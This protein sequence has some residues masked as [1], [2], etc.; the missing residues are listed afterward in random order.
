MVVTLSESYNIS[1][2][3]SV[4]SDSI[5]DLDEI[6]QQD[7]AVYSL[8]SQSGRTVNEMKD[9]FNPDGE[10]FERQMETA[11]HMEQT[12]PEAQFVTFM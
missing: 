11:S 9:I 8:E 1:R 6:L 4:I 5:L 7:T 3:A 12:L 2:K 10:Y